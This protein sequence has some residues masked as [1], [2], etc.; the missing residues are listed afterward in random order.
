[1][2][3][4]RIN[5][6][7][8]IVPSY[9]NNLHHMLCINHTFLLAMAA[10]NTNNMMKPHWYI[11]VEISELPALSPGI[12]FHVYYHPWKRNTLRN[13]SIHRSILSPYRQSCQRQ[14]CF[15]SQVLLIS[16]DIECLVL[17]GTSRGDLIIYIFWRKKKKEKKSQSAR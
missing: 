13:I 12:S 11:V 10:N 5:G 16:S 6:I 7:V 9:Y 15:L 2:S 3:I 17:L 4:R 14:Y 1:M 8:M